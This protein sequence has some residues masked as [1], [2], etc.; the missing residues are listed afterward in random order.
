[1]RKLLSLAFLFCAGITTLF[2]QDNG[3]NPIF[4][5]NIHDLQYTAPQKKTTVGSVLGT[6]ASAAAGQ[7]NDTDHSDKIPAVSAAVKSAVGKVRRFSTVDE[8]A[9]EVHY[10]LTGEV[11]KIVTTTQTR[12]VEEKDS[13]GKTHKRVVTDY[14]ADIAVSLTLTNLSTAEKLTRTFKGS[15]DWLETAESESKAI[16]IALGKISRNIRSYFNST[17]P[18]T[19]NIVERGNEKKD[20]TKEVYIDL[21]SYIGAYK[22]MHFSVYVVGSVAGRETRQRIGK[23]KVTEVMGDDITLCKVQSGGK[24]IKAAID[25]GKN[26]LVVSED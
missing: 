10:D 5:V 26:L 20:K 25:G 3:L 6:I 2:A 16:D 14:G 8:T 24:E 18:L 17:F 15:A 23:L 12:T 11:T 1:M 9:A 21:G 19:A 4:N 13:K 7:T 22:G